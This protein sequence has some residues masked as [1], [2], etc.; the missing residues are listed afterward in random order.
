M[1]DETPKIKQ[2]RP[3][4]PGYEPPTARI[5]K[6]RRMLDGG[7]SMDTVVSWC[8]GVYPGVP[9]AVPPIPA[10]LWTVTAQKAR[11][12]IAQAKV[13]ARHEDSDGGDVKRAM[14][15]SRTLRLVELAIAR[16]DLQSAIRAQHMLNLIDRSYEEGGAAPVNPAVGHEEAVARIEHAASTLALARSRGALAAKSPAVI[17]VQADEVDEEDEEPVDTAP[18]N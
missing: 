3:G 1:T 17:D 8:M 5:A 10:K 6:V 15:R 12:Y 16:G 4:D 11:D 2:P 14:N 13:Q 7:A 9:E 18:A